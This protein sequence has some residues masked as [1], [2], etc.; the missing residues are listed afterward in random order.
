MTDL[1][2]LTDLTDRTIRSATTADEATVIDVITLAFSADPVARWMFPNPHQYLAYAPQVMQTFGGR[3]FDCGTAHVIEGGVGAALWLPPNVEPDEEALISVMQS[4]VA[5][6]DQADVFAVLE[7]M[8]K[9]HPDEPHW[10]LPLIGVDPAQQCKGFGS[11]LMQH[12]LQV[13]D[14]DGTPAYL[15][16]SNPRNIPLYQR[17]GF[18]LLDAIQVGASPPIF[19]MV[20]RPRV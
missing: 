20:R 4:G 5:E 3:A 9:A 17:L 16:S 6:Q 18:E 8:G 7:Q 14:R 1:T 2:D 12:A 19:P 15:E 10:Y 11:A 13:C